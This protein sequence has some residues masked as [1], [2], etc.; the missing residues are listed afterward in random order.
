[1]I[2]R[3]QFNKISVDRIQEV[4][5]GNFPGIIEPYLQQWR[6]W[7]QAG[8]SAERVFYI[9]VN[10][11]FAVD[12]ILFQDIVAEAATIFSLEA[13]IAY[14]LVKKA[15]KYGPIT[16]FTGDPA[17]CQWARSVPAD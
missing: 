15:T 10:E 2:Q 1:M 7:V 12:G 6:E 16:T 11:N 9:S 8:G 13:T 5:A 17:S 14:N 3:T 4:F